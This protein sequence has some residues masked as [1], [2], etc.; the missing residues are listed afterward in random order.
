MKMGGDSVSGRSPPQQ[1]YS[2]NRVKGK[3][4]HQTGLPKLIR[5][6]R[7]INK[8]P[9]DITTIDVNFLSVFVGRMNKKRK[10][11]NQ[12]RKKTEKLLLQSKIVLKNQ[13]NIIGRLCGKWNGGGGPNKKISVHFP[14]PEYLGRKNSKLIWS[15]WGR[16]GW[17]DA[18]K[19]NLCCGLLPQKLFQK[20]GRGK[21][22]QKN[23]LVCSLYLPRAARQQDFLYPVLMLGSIFFF[24]MFI[25]AFIA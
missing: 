7:T 18:A 10:E 12:K 11:N 4:C 2:K 6:V 1:I 20:T 5:A 19:N 14:M 15:A 8:A 25:R 24:F 13:I 21:T 9:K 22:T 23:K 16:V 17:N 3:E